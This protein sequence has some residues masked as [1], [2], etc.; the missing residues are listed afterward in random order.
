MSTRLQDRL[1]HVKGVLQWPVLR[2]LRLAI[3]LRWA[4][5]L[6][7][8]K[9]QKPAGHESGVV[10]SSHLSSARF[11]HSSPMRPAWQSLISGQ[12]RNDHSPTAVGVSFPAFPPAKAAITGAGLS[13]SCAS[14]VKEGTS[15]DVASKRDD[16]QILSSVFRQMSDECHCRGCRLHR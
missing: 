4:C 11:S 6:L 5:R 16:R 14:S 10:L 8:D 7:G 12:K 1:S 2:S 3:L 15:K 9:R 13:L